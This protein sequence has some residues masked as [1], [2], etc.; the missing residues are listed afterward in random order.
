M[1]AL[2]AGCIP[3]IAS[4]GYVLPKFDNPSFDWRSFSFKF[5]ES[6]IDAIVPFLRSLDP[7][8]IVRMHENV[9]DV[10]SILERG[11]HLVN[12][13]PLILSRIHNRRSTKALTE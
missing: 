3:I 9:K 13:I 12:G 8:T 6:E 4:D 10:Y 5:A 11:T 1:E 2:S 7:K